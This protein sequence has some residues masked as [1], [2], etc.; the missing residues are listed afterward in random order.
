[1]SDAPRQGDTHIAAT[2]HVAKT[3]T[4]FLQLFTRITLAE[5]ISLRWRP[6]R[7]ARTWVLN[8]STLP[9][10]TEITNNRGSHGHV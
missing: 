4:R 9:F 10:C 2:A 1:M 3:I 8:L 7:N 5:S 6:V